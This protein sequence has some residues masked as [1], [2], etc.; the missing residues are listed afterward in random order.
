MM[1]VYLSNGKKNLSDG[2]RRPLLGEDNPVMIKDVDKERR[3][4]FMPE[5]AHCI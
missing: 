5:N 3:A 4:R 2:V 1:N